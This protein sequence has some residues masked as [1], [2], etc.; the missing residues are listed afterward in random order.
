[1]SEMATIRAVLG[2]VRRSILET[3][4]GV[5]GGETWR[6][7]PAIHPDDGAAYRTGMSEAAMNRSPGNGIHSVSTLLVHLAGAE[8]YWICGVIGGETV[9]RQREAEFRHETRSKAAV[10]AAYREAAAAADRVLDGLRDGDLDRQV[11]TG[12]T[13]GE[14]LLRMIAHSAHHRGQ[15]L[16][17]KRLLHS[18]RAGSAGEP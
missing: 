18:A 16:L 9:D 10:A 3:V 13:V 11:Q 12:A 15:I 4:E 6:P 2:G 5:P 17:L 8:R 7:G 1:M 14:I